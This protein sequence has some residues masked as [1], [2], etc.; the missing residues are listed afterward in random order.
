MGGPGSGRRPKPTALKVL[1]GTRGDRI[2][3]AEPQLPIGAIV[4]PATL[5][6]H[7][8]TKW[9]ELAPLMANAGMFTEGD[10]SA[11]TLLCED[12]KAIQDGQA[13][14]DTKNRFVKLLTEFGLTPASRS[15]LKA[16]VEPPKDKLST[17]LDRAKRKP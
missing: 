2:N 15:R 13:S 4:A 3:H 1:D 14:A 17:H 11:L 12:Y 8:L 7:A 10:R 9:N 6:G 16:R 5:E